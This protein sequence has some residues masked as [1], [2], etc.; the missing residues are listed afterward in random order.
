MKLLHISDLHFHRDLQNNIAADELLGTISQRYPKHTLIITGDIS[1]DGTP[2][3]FEN[4]FRA[5]ES[6]VGRVFIAPGNHDFGSA[7]NFYS[8][9][10]ALRFDQMLSNPLRQGGTFTGDTTPVVNFVRDGNDQVMLI[11]LDTNLE[12]EHPF[13]FACGELGVSQ[14]AAL[15][16]ILCNP[17]NATYTKVL[18]FHH[19]PFI[20]NDPFMELKDAEELM[21][22]IY[23]R[24]D[25]VLFGH[26]HVVGEWHGLCR[27]KLILASDDSPDKDWAKE[28]D[29]QGKTITVTPVWI[30][31]GA[32][33]PSAP[34]SARASKAS[35][36]IKSGKEREV[37]VRDAAARP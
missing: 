2:W 27:T 11:A 5:L 32:S 15:N 20:H 23:G 3:Q 17:A 6:F 8:Q 7:G 35:A 19:H 26:K 12:T 21:R 18:F 9:E 13:D 33:R 34:A 37:N 29:I 16:T 31:P 25:V 30:R 10:R 24:V 36:S 28:I 4:A 22:T 14:L 1:D